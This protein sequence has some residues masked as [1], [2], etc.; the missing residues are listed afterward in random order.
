M[1]I[2]EIVKNFIELQPESYCNKGYPCCIQC[3]IDAQIKSSVTHFQLAKKP[4]GKNNS[5]KFLPK[6]MVLPGMPPCG[7]HV[8]HATTVLRL[9]V[10]EVAD[11]KVITLSDQKF[12]IY[13]YM[14]NNMTHE[15]KGSNF[16]FCLNY[17]TN[18][19]HNSAVMQFFKLYLFIMASRPQQILRYILLSIDL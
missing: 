10:A 15:W 18:L 8:I 5:R 3:K 13:I 19:L 12:V 4:T 2:V 9:A 14:Y 16:V 11:E 6:A 17:L 7:N 1:C